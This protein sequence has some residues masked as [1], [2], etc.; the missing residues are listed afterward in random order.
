LSKRRAYKE[1]SDDRCEDF[2]KEGATSARSTSEKGWASDPSNIQVNHQKV[3]SCITKTSGASSKPALF[4]K[5]YVC[6]SFW[7]S[8][9]YK[10]LMHMS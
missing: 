2:S 6:H 8:L 9:D 3:T 4:I 7:I 10:K 5:R 1:V